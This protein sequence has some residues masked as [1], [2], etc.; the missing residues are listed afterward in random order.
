MCSDTRKQKVISQ[1]E[2]QLQRGGLHFK[3]HR[4]GLRSHCA[5]G[6]NLMISLCDCFPQP[7]DEYLA[8]QGLVQSLRS[9]GHGCI[10]PPRF[11]VQVM[12]RRPRAA[13]LRGRMVKREKEKEK[14]ENPPAEC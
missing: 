8:D 2:S 7:G 14:E 3:L 5:G 12:E 11:I 9:C 4:E 10:A 1:M 6:G 13:S